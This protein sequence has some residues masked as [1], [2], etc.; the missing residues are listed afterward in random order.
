MSPEHPSEYA[1]WSQNEMTQLFYDYLIQGRMNVKDLITSC[2]SPLDAPG[3]YQQLLTGRSGQI[4]IILD[5]NQLAA[6]LSL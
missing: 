2:I 3:V 1:P 4:G 5:W 6:G